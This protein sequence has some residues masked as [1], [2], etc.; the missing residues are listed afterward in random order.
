[1]SIRH[2]AEDV[3]IKVHRTALPQRLW[4][5]F[6]QGLDQPETFISGAQIGKRSVIALCQSMM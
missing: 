4:E 3:A 1:M 2:L 6:S 5:H